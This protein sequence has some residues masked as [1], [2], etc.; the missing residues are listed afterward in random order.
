MSENSSNNQVQKSESNNVELRRDRPDVIPAELLEGL[1]PEQV[2]EL[3]M[4]YASGR[5]T[6]LLKDEATKNAVANL[7]DFLNSAV[8]AAGKAAEDDTSFTTSNVNESEIGRTETI[9]GNTDKA[10]SGRVDQSVKGR[11]NQT[12]VI[13]GFAGVVIVALVLIFVLGS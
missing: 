9:V 13:V 10:A 1:A 4:Q 8:T 7:G 5:I 6:N 2:A 12:I 3:Q 11:P